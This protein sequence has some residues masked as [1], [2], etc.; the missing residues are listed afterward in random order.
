MNKPL[1]SWKKSL[2]ALGYKV[3]WNAVFRSK[4][5][6][7]LKRRQQELANQH[8]HIEN[9]E[10][11]QMLS[12]VTDFG[13]ESNQLTV[14]GTEAS[15]TIS[16]SSVDGFVQVGNQQ[17][18]VAAS[19]VQQIDVSGLGGNDVINLE[20]VVTAFEFTNLSSTTISGGDGS[21]VI[22]GSEADDLIL[23]G[24]GDDTIEGSLGDDTIVGGSGY[25]QVF[26]DTSTGPAGEW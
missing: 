10:D 17:T 9:L 15:D 26:D 3:N 16:I 2:A 7:A 22:V 11:R 19:D 14:V 20:G 12:T 1:T 21:D 6:K 18:T 4:K 24:A 13:F 23:G 8:F 5:Q 25:D